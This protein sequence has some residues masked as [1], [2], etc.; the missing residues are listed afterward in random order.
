VTNTPEAE[1]L[2][3][4]NVLPNTKEQSQTIVVSTG[5]K[6]KSQ[7]WRLQ[8]DCCQKMK[9]VYGNLHGSAV[10]S[11]NAVVP[12]LAYRNWQLLCLCSGGRIQ[13]ILTAV[14]G[15]KK[16]LCLKC[17][18]RATFRPQFISHF[19][20]TSRTWLHKLSETNFDPYASADN[21]ALPSTLDN[22]RTNKERKQETAFEMKTVRGV[23]SMHT[24]F[25]F[26]LLWWRHNQERRR[27]PLLFAACLSQ[28]LTAPLITKDYVD[29]GKDVYNG[30]IRGT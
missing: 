28:T 8:C 19:G 30:T 1:A 24:M 14:S 22:C 12:V 18:D 4:S 27:C 20:S 26:L 11:R 5:N 29:M 9:G 3:F 2:G 10:S 21:R 25:L 23:F 7:R 15:R 13:P 6:N 17:H 16:G